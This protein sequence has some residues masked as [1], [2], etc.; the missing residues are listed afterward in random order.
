[1]ET[2]NPPAPDVAPVDP[3]SARGSLDWPPASQPAHGRRWG[4]GLLLGGLG[5]AVAVLL[6]YVA[7]GIIGTAYRE[8]HAGQV[9]FGAKIANSCVIEHP[10]TD[11]TVGTPLYWAA[12][13]HSPL[14]PGTT[15]AME[16]LLDEHVVSTGRY[17]ESD[18][19]TT[20]IFNRA[21]LGPLPPGEY[22]LR[23]RRDA[24]VL[25]EGN[26]T[27]RSA[28]PAPMAS[29][30]ATPIPTSELIGCT[31]HGAPALESQLPRH[32]GGSALTICS[33]A[34]REWLQLVIGSD[35]EIDTVLRQFKGS[36][37]PIDVTHLEGAA[38]VQANPPGA[39]YAVSRPLDENEHDLATFLLLLSA[40]YDQPRRVD[41][42]DY[43][44]RDFGDRVVFVGDAGMI[45]PGASRQGRPYLYQTL[46]VMFIILTADEDWA[47]AAIR[48][49]PCC[50]AN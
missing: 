47:E 28:T 37:A 38:A 50:W 43:E 42:A 7:S 26:A 17:V 21:P 35:A 16:L 48:Q 31:S 12:F 15:L 11:F 20:C 13:F 9:V 36:G 22:A 4:R 18:E 25:A 39:V 27:V 46:T 19:G 10:E 41:L 34:G 32:V 30:G 5:A 33:K 8:S 40:G 29:S 44:P 49:L 6:G 23:I 2:A 45:D 1:V 3:G 14:T 24:E